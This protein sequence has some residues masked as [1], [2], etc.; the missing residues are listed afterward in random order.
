[1]ESHKVGHN[2]VCTLLLIYCTTVFFICDWIKQSISEKSIW[3]WIKSIIYFSPSYLKCEDFYTSFI[4]H[5]GS[6]HRIC[7]DTIWCFF[8]K[9][10]VV[11]IRN[12]P[13]ISPLLFISN[14]KYITLFP[15]IYI[16]II[17][18][19][20][21]YW[22]TYLD[23]EQVGTE[24][25]RKNFHY[26]SLKSPRLV[27]DNY[28]W[29]FIHMFYVYRELVFIIIINNIYGFVQCAILFQFNY[30]LL[31]TSWLLNPCFYK[32]KSGFYSQKTYYCKLCFQW[33]FIWAIVL[34]HLSHRYGLREALGQALFYKYLVDMSNTPK[35]NICL[36]FMINFFL[37]L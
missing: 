6:R 32:T 23:L 24:L 7:N 9:D 13:K 29:V 8:W 21:I 10:K 14:Y 37:V 31:F 36:L 2:W 3:Y 17:V 1:M 4:T 12:K 28:I 15:F 34:K 33:R 19:V 16:S 27:E 25:S 30:F 26:L 11:L 35:K 22:F 20:Y 18:R 5:W